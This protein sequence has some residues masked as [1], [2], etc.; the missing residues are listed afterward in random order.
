MQ[1]L[2]RRAVYIDWRLV[3]VVEHD[4]IIVEPQGTAP[5]ASS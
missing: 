1:L 2:H 3:R 5:H 4:R